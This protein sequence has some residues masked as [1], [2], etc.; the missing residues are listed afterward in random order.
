[1]HDGAQQR[2]VSLALQLRSVE[3]Q[4]PPDLGKLRTD[5]SDAV[6]E[7]VTAS[8]DLRE[9]A[10][11]IH[12]A[13][14]SRGG[15]GPALKTLA[16]RCAIPVTLH[17]EVE[18]PVSEPAQIAAYYVVAEVL[19]NAARYSHA[20]GV[21]IDARTGGDKLTIS[22]RDDGVGGADTKNGSGLIGLIDRLEALG[23]HLR[24]VSPPGAG[25]TLEATIPTSA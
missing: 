20:S 24:V 6:S 23:G 18:E 11:G 17:V 8:A 7:L 13:I 4:V 15:L 3:E 12:P 22:I 9:I 19:T 10:R 5:I 16:R 14:A 2:L 1:L 25:T 21:D